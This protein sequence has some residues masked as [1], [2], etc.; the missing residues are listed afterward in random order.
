MD[1]SPAVVTGL[2]SRPQVTLAVESSAP[3]AV[4][5]T[6]KVVAVALASPVH[7]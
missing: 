4:K 3:S 1:R 5:A 7:C 2:P 6:L